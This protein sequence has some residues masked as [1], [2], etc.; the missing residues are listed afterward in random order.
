MSSATCIKV[1]SLLVLYAL[2]VQ[3]RM[4]LLALHATRRVLLLC[5]LF[6]FFLSVTLE[7]TCITNLRE[8]GHVQCN[9]LGLWINPRLTAPSS[10]HVQMDSYNHPEGVWLC[11]LRTPR[12]SL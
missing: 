7:W 2:P 10:N 3:Y 4:L 9:L 6:F 5:W 12:T 1:I 11:T 8:T